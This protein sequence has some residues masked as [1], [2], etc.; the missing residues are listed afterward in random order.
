MK[1]SAPTKIILFGE[2]YVVYGAPALS[3]AVSQ[4]R[5]VL[6]EEITYAG[7]EKIE[8]INPV[9]NEGGTIY[10]DGSSEGHRHVQMHAAIYKEVYS[11]AC[12]RLKGRAFR[13]EFLGGRIFKGMGGSSA[14]GACIAKGLYEY[15]GINA[16]KEE[17]FRC[18][19]I[20]DE[21][22]HGGRPSG[23]DARTVVYGGMIKF[24][25]EFNPSRY[26][27][28]QMEIKLP[29][30]TTI[31]IVDTFRGVRCNTGDQVLLFA[32]NNGI[33]KKPDEMSAQERK[34]VTSRYGEIFDRAVEQLTKDD[35]DPQQLA[36]LIAEN[37]SLLKRY[38]MSTP[39]IEEAIS[40]IMDNGGLGAKITGAGGEGGA[41]IGYVYRNDLRGIQSALKERGFE[42]IE[43]EPTNIGIKRD[44]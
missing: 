15:A 5:E 35:G 20:G 24:W 17:I 16:D 37:H 42:S 12:G 8:I 9:Y 27:F 22:D 7:K 4:R 23:I 29:K 32:R 44:A 6:F 43:L 1:I 40:I 10:P 18:A 26:N 28:E 13:A 36:Q 39:V 14:L 2:H 19:Q 38:G 21:V 11:R 34:R 25:K 3:V 30:G 41:L 33:T 31:L